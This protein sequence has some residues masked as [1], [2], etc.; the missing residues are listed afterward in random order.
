MAF[1]ESCEI[2][3]LQAARRAPARPER[4]DYILLPAEICERDGTS[5]QRGGGK[6]G[7][8]FVDQ[9]WL[10]AFAFQR[11]FKQ[12]RAPDDQNGERGED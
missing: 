1:V 12:V 10:F 6:I 7:R 8:P 4:H 11:E 3:H 9:L 5:I 2:R